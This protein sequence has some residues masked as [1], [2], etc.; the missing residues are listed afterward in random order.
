VQGPRAGG[1][2]FVITSLAIRGGRLPWIIVVRQI[3]LVGVVAAILSLAASALAQPGGMPP[4]RVRVTPV[5]ERSVAIGR[6]FVGSVEAVQTSTLGSMVEGRVEELLVDE[7]D[8]VEKGAVIAKLRRVQAELQL[9]IAQRQLQLS[10]QTR[11]ELLQTLP[12]EIEQARAQ[13]MAAEALNKF[14]QARLRRTQTLYKRNSVTEDELQ[15]KESAAAA[16]A[17]KVLENR[18]AWRALEGSREEKIAKARL[19][20]LLDQDEVARL[21]DDLDQHTIVAPFAGHV[22]EEHTEVGQWVAKGAPVVEMMN[23]D[24]V[25]VEVP[26]PEQY[27]S[28]VERGITARITVPALP[29]WS[30]E[31]PVTAR[32][33]SGDVQSRTF[34][35]RVRL[36]N[37]PAPDG[38]SRLTPGMF[39]QVTLPVGQREEAL[40]V[41]KDAVV[42][43][44]EVPVVYV[45]GPMPGP[46]GG[47]AGPGGAAKPPAGRGGPPGGTPAAGPAPDGVARRVPVEL[48]AAVEGLI[49]VRGPL[50]AGDRVVV[51]GNER[52]MPGQPL[53][54]VGERPAPQS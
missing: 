33:P 41:P 8:R 10:E 6:T 29:G 47:G 3:A 38:G 16:A 4:A 39:A 43:G 17:E 20:V 30:T 54:I 48:G 2:G 35:V 14:A 18:A 34:R 28:R 53:I 44:G 23:L 37:E 1:K 40:L 21:Q 45:I 9:T 46:P 31:A 42:P 52:L 7:G 27:Y 32:V 25:E 15:E 36:D 13:A 22:T 12:E 51:E 49:E 11:D 24:Q 5:V 19:Q 50:K 26:V